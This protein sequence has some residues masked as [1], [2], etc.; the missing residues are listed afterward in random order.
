MEEQKYAHWFWSKYGIF[1]V[2]PTKRQAVSGIVESVLVKEKIDSR[3]WIDNR[4]S[5]ETIRQKTVKEFS[6]KYADE[7]TEIL[8]EAEEIELKYVYIEVFASNRDLILEKCQERFTSVH[9]DD[10]FYCHG[11][12]NKCWIVRAGNEEAPHP[13]KNIDEEHYI[14]WICNNVDY[15]C[16]ADP[17]MGKGNGWI[18]FQCCR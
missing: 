9:I 17:C 14:R 15:N 12:K 16:I 5:I 18:L 7:F 13:D 2:P 4:N 10:S 6:D 11:R 3:F 8:K 1:N